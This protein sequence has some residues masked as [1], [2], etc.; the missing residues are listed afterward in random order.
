MRITCPA[1]GLNMELEADA[2]WGVLNCADCGKRIRFGEQP[3][4]RGEDDIGFDFDVSLPATSESVQPKTVRRQREWR[5]AIIAGAVGAMAMAMLAVLVIVLQ[6][7]MV[8]VTAASA[9]PWDQAHRAELLNLKTS[10]DSL[11]K[12]GKWQESYDGY[13]KILSLVGDHPVTDPVAV[14]MVQAVGPGQD[15]AVAAMTAMVANRAMV[16]P[17]ASAN[18]E[19]KPATRPVVVAI[20]V[21]FFPSSQ[22]V[23]PQTQPV[24]AVAR[25]A[26]TQA[27]AMPVSQLDAAELGADTAPPL[28]G[29]PPPPPSLHAYTLPS[30]V[31]DEQIGEAINKAVKFLA[32]QFAGGQISLK[33]RGNP[34]AVVLPVKPPVPKDLSDL[35]HSSDLDPPPVA[36]SGQTTPRTVA[37]WTSAYSLPGIDALCVYAL[38]NA[39]R[40]LD[41]PGLGPEDP[42]TEQILDQLKSY[43]MT[44][45]YHR[46]LRAA[47]L[48]VFARTQDNAA[49]EDDVRWLVNANVHGGYTYVMPGDGDQ[50]YDNSNSQYGLLGV[51][52][53]AQ[54]GISIPTTYWS[55]VESH[56]NGCAIGDGTWGYS[57]GAGSS[58][59]MTC[60]GVASLLVAR[61]YLD[62]AAGT[63]PA[64]SRSIDAGLAWLD[65]GDNSVNTLHNGGMGGVGYGLYG[66]ERVGLASGFKYFGKHDWYSELARTLVAEQNLNGSWGDPGNGGIVSQT[67]LINTAYSLLF[68][69]R[70]RHP[71][72]FNKLRYDGPWNNYP[73]DVAHL[74]RYAA[75]ELERPLN[76]QV[77]NL[78]R[79]WFDWMDCPVL[80]IA[81]D[82]QPGFTD[83]DYA[84]L[85]SFAEGGGTILTHADGGSAA[86]N[87]WVEALVRKIFPRYELMQVPRD[88]PLYSTVYQIKDPPPLLAVSNGS[89]LL[90]IHSP[91]DIAGGWQLNWTDEKKPAFQMGINLFVY[92]AGKGNLKNRLASSYIPED[93]EHA[94][95]TRPIARLQYAGEWDPEPYAYKRFC[96]YFQWETRQA[97]QPVTVQMKSLQPNSQ[98]LAVLTGTVAHDFTDAETTAASA[99][100][101][102][103]GVLMI[104]ACGGR[105]DFAK[106]VEETLL[107]KAFAGTTPVAI[108]DNHPLLVP[109]RAHADDLTKPMLRAFAAENGGKDFP[110][111]VIACGKGWVIFS[112]LDLTTG[113]LGTQSWGILGY[114]S[115][116]AQALMKNAVLWAEARSPAPATRPH[117]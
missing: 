42:L 108:A 35:D 74:A 57:E 99:Y 66:L 22:A 13:Q 72:L 102:A 90:L 111:E 88:H 69:A 116:Y 98:P 112:R 68:L 54:A 115:A 37:R 81:G 79:N 87:K 31:T 48:A 73:H 106:S 62:S 82:K 3:A 9:V 33:M 1:C 47:A 101:S 77:V 110:I 67:T 86:F 38:L 63:R 36:P 59:T 105:P 71:I 34:A 109:S 25:P 83:H 60:A 104:D 94:E 43:E 46:S 49:L 97:I 58:L 55:E 96:R 26:T 29:P 19:P 61:D 24:V 76:W 70:G 85:R 10:A 45:T 117:P 27:A 51:W 21:P 11:A 103:G 44:Y 89:R 100:V 92:A 95:S 39:G 16:A 4:E 5:K 91:T 113:L 93:P 84:A 7:A 15:R 23:V 78:R 6:R 40:A 53:G 14:A 18:V 8:P 52:S 107:A 56:W 64:P 2:A 28:A 30:A 75:H 80:Y 32:G 12:Q 41:V 114:S 50:G 20:A 65:A 17:A